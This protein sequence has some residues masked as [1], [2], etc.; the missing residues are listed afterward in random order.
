MRPPIGLNARGRGRYSAQKLLKLATIVPITA[1]ADR[2]ARGR[3][4]YSAQKL[5]KLATIVPSTA[6]VTAKPA[7][8]M[9]AQWAAR[10]SDGRAVSST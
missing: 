7:E 4:R 6:A 9:K 10:R 5:L 8:A 2:Q 3:G 1:A